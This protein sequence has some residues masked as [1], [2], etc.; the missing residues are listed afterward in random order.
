MFLQSF[1]VAHGRMSGLI[2]PHIEVPCQYAC[3]RLRFVVLG[4]PYLYDILIQ[5]SGLSVRFFYFSSYIGA[6]ELLNNRNI[7][8][9]ARDWLVVTQH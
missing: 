8:S 5:S 1:S 7:I 2:S 6:D 4:L 3:V 9:N